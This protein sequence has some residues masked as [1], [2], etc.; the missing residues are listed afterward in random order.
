MSNRLCALLGITYPI[1]QGGMGNISSPELAAAV[2][3]AGGLGTIGAGTMPPEELEKKVGKVMELTDRPYSVNIPLSVQPFLKETVELVTRYRVPLVSLSAG[4]PDALI[5]H[6]HQ[7]GMK[8]AVVVGTVK[9]A[10]KAELAGADFIV[11]EGFEAAGINSP[12]EITTMSLIPQV[13]DHVSLPV[14]AAGGI[15]DHRGFAAALALGAC[16]IQ[17]GTR[18]VATKEAMV[19][20]NYKEAILQSPDTGTVVV[21]RSMGSVRRLLDTP[22]A[23]ELLKKEGNDISQMEYMRL[24]DE[25]SHVRGAIEGR[26]A[27]GH[28]NCGQIGGMINQVVSVK[29]LLASIVKGA[30]NVIR[31]AREQ[32]PWT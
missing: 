29:D 2:S 3:E 32:L 15:A 23:R 6:F 14:V 1:I 10:V 22:Y 28:V 31:E 5:A 21:G 8:V 12:A 30:E 13:V 4:K 17:M 25:A 27:E 9:H 7:A 18:F 24:T 26:L 20:P 11:A 19:H 16:G